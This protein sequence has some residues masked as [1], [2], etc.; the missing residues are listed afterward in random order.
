MTLTELNRHFE[1]REKLEKAQETL[2]ILRQRAHPGAAALTGMPHT[3]GVSDKVGDLAAEIADMD[4]YIAAIEAEVAA[5]EVPVLAFICSIEDAQ[6]RLVLRLRFVRGLS[7]KEVSQVLGQYTSESSVKSTCYRF[8]REH[9][10]I[11]CPEEENA[12]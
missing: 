4:A 7:W 6:I 10:A 9:G 5:S 12:L 3:P 1:L 11:T 8:L 2:A